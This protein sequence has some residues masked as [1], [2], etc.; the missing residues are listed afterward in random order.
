MDQIS[1]KGAKGWFRPDLVWWL[2][3][4]GVAIRLAFL[5]VLNLFPEEAYYWN[6]SRHLDIGYL[7]HP[8]M[9]AWTIHAS[10]WLLGRSE[11]AVR[12]PAFLSWFVMAFFMYRLTVEIVDR[13]AGRVVLLLLAA[14]PIYLSVG[15]MMTPDAPLYA[16]WAACLYFLYRALI[17]E[18]N[19][20]WWW[21]GLSL[22]LGLFSKYTMGLIVPAA[23]IFMLVDRP[24]RRWLRRPEPY[25]A[26]VI[27]ALVFSPVIY[28]NY[29]HDWASFAFQGSRRWSG[30]MH[31]SLH[32]LL[33]SILVLLTPVGAYVAYRAMRV[34]W[35]TLRQRYGPIETVRQHLFMMVFT[36]VPLAVFV[37]HS[38]QGQP[39]LNWT[40]PVWLALLPLMAVA[41]RQ[42]H[43]AA[44]P[45]REGTSRLLVT[46]AAVLLIL[47]TGAF[48][49]VAVGT[50]GLSLGKGMKLP[51][52]WRA[53]GERVD[54]IEE[55]IEHETGSE[56]M[57]VGLDQ[58]WIASQLAFYDDD[59][60]QPR[61]QDEG[62]ETGSAELFG[63][64]SLMWNVWSTPQIATSR[65]VLL[66]SFSASE[67][68]HSWITRHF[69]SVGPVN[70]EVLG[71]AGDGSPRFYWRFARKYRE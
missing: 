7:D 24:S 45:V 70:E 37:F 69:E 38:L 63:R 29:L 17:N 25:L 34:A 44:K 40:G 1:D 62:P 3:G 20:A 61:D 32:L 16:A 48:G 18:R 54:Q 21:A 56:P 30:G 27:A 47:Y 23:F 68:D 65:N 36:V 58:Y 43:A 11:F 15:F 57:I 2:I 14:L 67:L 13:K 50:P 42:T 66:I 6:Y 26:L 8:P 12:L 41:L 28:W 52:A 49:Y 59:D 64:N 31:F 9:V 46:T 71:D 55:R 33:G 4:L 53:M 19:S 35:R 22:G 10:E 5:G 39:K 51:T 60:W